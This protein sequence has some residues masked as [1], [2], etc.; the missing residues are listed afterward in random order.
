[1]KNTAT[2]LG[3]VWQS[4]GCDAFHWQRVGRKTI[5]GNGNSIKYQPGAWAGGQTWQGG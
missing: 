3:Y 4:S 5:K 1:V 2:R